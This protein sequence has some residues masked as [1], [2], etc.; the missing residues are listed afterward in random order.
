MPASSTTLHPQ[1]RDLPVE[2]LGE[3]GAVAPDLIL[4]AKT[5]WRRMIRGCLAEPGEDAHEVIVT[6]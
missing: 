4:R 1:G 3:L 6:T 2:L 5:A